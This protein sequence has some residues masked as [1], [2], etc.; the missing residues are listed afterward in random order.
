MKNLV[1]SFIKYPFYANVIIVVLLLAGVGSLM[2]TKKSFFPEFKSRIINVTVSYPGAS[3]KEMEE[4]I[5]TRI[6]ES[7]RGIVG[8]KEVTSNSMENFCRVRIETTGKYDLDVTVQEVKNAV[9]AIS[10]GVA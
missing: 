6:E 3:P 9:D 1:K 8:I 7:V 4:G 10:S 2:N 5:T